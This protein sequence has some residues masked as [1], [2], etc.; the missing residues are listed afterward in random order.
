MSGYS[1]TL[2]C[3]N[4]LSELKYFIVRDYLKKTKKPTKLDQFWQNWVRGD[5][6]CSD[7]SSWEGAATSPGIGGEVWISSLGKSAWVTADTAS[8][9]TSELC[10]TGL[11]LSLASP[12]VHFSI[13]KKYVRWQ[14]HQWNSNITTS[15][16]TSIPKKS[17]N[18]LAVVRRLWGGAMGL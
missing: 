14:Q 7:A 5:C 4:D 6:A 17:R 2:C 3:Q 1:L 9:T 13:K 18:L 12:S 15:E 10:L 11:S 16:G 8:A